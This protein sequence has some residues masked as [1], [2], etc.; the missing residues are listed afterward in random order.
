MYLEIIGGRSVIPLLP[1]YEIGHKFFS[2]GNNKK[3]W[4]KCG[5]LASK[6]NI[7]NDQF[8]NILK[9]QIQSKSKHLVNRA[10]IN[11][12]AKKN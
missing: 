3:F 12:Y 8:I 10:I 11:Y 1:K 7:E 9:K 4:V 6:Y 2:K 5:Q